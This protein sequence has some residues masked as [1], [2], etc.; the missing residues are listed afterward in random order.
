MT[1]TRLSQVATTLNENRPSK[2]GL[3]SFLSEKKEE[4]NERAIEER[5]SSQRRNLPARLA[6]KV[7]FRRWTREDMKPSDYL[8]LLPTTYGGHSEIAREMDE[9]SRIGISRVDG[10]NPEVLE[11]LDWYDISGA[12]NTEN[13]EEIGVKGEGGE[14]SEQLGIDTVRLE[15]GDKVYRASPYA[16]TPF[17]VQVEVAEVEESGTY[18]DMDSVAE[19]YLESGQEEGVDAVV[20]MYENETDTK[21]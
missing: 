8:D 17:Q 5:R 18:E 7:E 6:Q 14:V 19:E 2:E 3:K 21:W 12:L 13:G 10:D 1:Q 15:E 11:S 20:T 9:S 4:L 16:G